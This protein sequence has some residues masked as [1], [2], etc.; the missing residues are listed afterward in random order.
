MKCSKCL[1]DNP[2]G[3]V[4]C[5]K[6]QLPLAM[7][8]NNEVPRT[9]GSADGDFEFR[10]GQ[11]VNGRF[12]VLDLI[13]RGGMGRIYKVHDNVLGEDVGGAVAT[14]GGLGLRR[15]AVAAFRGGRGVDHARRSV[16]HRLNR[17]LWLAGIA[18]AFG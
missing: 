7:S 5:E 2:S 6:C 18:L 8:S 11:V 9:S 15:I 4:H 17:Q 13:G 14:L 12:T 10:R 3:L 1:H 16:G